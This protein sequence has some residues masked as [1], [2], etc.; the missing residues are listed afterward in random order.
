[1]PVRRPLVL[2]FHA[3]RAVR[4]LVLLHDEQLRDFVDVWRRAR[5][6]GLALPPCADPNYASLDALLTHVG[7]A[8]RG[9][10]TWICEQLR[11][12]DPD[13]PPVPAAEQLPAAFEGWLEALLAGWTRALAGVRDEQLEQPEY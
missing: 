13:L 9:Y 8:A 7:R 3:S 1:M 5:A 10:L 12:P 6:A 4:A 11:L 2:P